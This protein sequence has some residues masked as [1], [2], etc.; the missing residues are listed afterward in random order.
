MYGEQTVKVCDWCDE[1]LRANPFTRT[2]GDEVFLFCSEQHRDDHY[3][4]LVQG[5]AN[6]RRFAFEGGL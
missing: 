6:Q 2:I 4:N 3:L 5:R 1:R